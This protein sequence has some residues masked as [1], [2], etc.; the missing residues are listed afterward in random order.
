MFRPDITYTVD[1]ALKAV[2]YLLSYFSLLLRQKPS[3]DSFKSD[4]RTFLSP[5]QSSRPAMFSPLALLTPGVVSP[6]S[7][8]LVLESVSS[9]LVH[10]DTC[11]SARVSVGLGRYR[12]KGLSAIVS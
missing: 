2:N 12:R 3:L 10:A 4:L 9:S 5:F 6:S 11:E 7:A 8:K 1:W